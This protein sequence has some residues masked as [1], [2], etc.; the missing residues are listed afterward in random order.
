MNIEETKEAI[1]VMKAFVD[2]KDLEV[3]GPV[4]KWEP[5][6]FPRWGWDDTKYRIKPT[7][8][9]RPWT[10]DEVPV[11]A[12]LRY[13]GNNQSI[14]ILIVC[15]QQAGLCG[16]QTNFPYDYLRDEMEHST[17]CGKTWLPCGVME[18][19]K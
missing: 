16:Y 13:K 11:G 3:L 7:Y 12:I 2:G 19:S 15:N 18:E 14:R 9:L 5:L 17:D 4:G 1:H 8:V 6:Y 10:A